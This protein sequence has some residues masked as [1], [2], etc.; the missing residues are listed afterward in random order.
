MSHAHD[1]AEAADAAEAARK[2]RE[3]EDA[4]GRLATAVNRE[5]KHMD[6]R[7]TRKPPEKKRRRLEV[8]ASRRANRRRK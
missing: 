8:Q 7:G 1:L 3:A 6:L 5:K 4:I 2:A